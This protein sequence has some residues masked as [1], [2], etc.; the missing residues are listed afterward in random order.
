MY[1][2][3]LLKKCFS[4][5][6]TLWLDPL[7]EREWFPNIKTWTEAF[8]VRSLLQTKGYAD[9]NIKVRVM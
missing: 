2:S 1:S 5:N 7:V 4:L 8:S 6:A 3:V 9:E